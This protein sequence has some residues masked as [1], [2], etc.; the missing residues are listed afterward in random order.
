MTFEKK[1]YETLYA[2]VGIADEVYKDSV[3]NMRA[4]HE[5]TI[6][7]LR[8]EIVKELENNLRLINVYEPVHI[9]KQR[10]TVHSMSVTVIKKD[11]LESL[12]EKEQKYERIK[13]FLSSLETDERYTESKEIIKEQEE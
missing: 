12:L 5:Q 11:Y 2:A 10:Q 6:H 7:S 9:P 13:E 3:L 8:C 1:D 4:L